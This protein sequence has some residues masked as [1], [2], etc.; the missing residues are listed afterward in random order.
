LIST[1]ET[2]P[3]NPTLDTL[4]RIGEA[5]QIDAGG[6]ISKAR[7]RVL[8]RQGSNARA[9]AALPAALKSGQ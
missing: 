5:L 2:N 1:L 8:K 6:I 9:A 3:W 4:L 7:K